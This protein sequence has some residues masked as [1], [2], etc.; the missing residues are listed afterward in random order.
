MENLSLSTNV[1]GVLKGHDPE[2]FT[3]RGEEAI[4]RATEARRT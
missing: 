2:R 4:G 3:E 1:S